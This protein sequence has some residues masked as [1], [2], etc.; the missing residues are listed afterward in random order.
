M[1]CTSRGRWVRAGLVLLAIALG[2][3]AEAWLATRTARTARLAKW[4]FGILLG[5]SLV[6][7][8]VMS[9]VIEPAGGELYRIRTDLKP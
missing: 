7:W 3:A 1:A 8:Q 4:T 6:G 5:G 2:C 9:F